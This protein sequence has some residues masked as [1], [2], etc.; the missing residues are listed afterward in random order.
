MVAS[1]RL[2]LS[3]VNHPIVWYNTCM[4][5]ALLYCTKACTVIQ[6][7]AMYLKSLTSHHCVS[8][9]P[10]FAVAVFPPSLTAL[11]YVGEW[12]AGHVYKSI[13]IFYRRAGQ[14]AFAQP[15]P[16]RHM[17]PTFAREANATANLNLQLVIS[18]SDEAQNMAFR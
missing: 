6:C 11:I 17:R 3:F 12:D 14:L 9:P 4:H 15:F 5:G 7:I 16:P 13:V 18:R 1:L 8:C 2:A 10:L